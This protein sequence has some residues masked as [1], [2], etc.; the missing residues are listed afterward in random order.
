MAR[1]QNGINQELL[2]FFQQAVGLSFDL[3]VFGAFEDFLQRV[4]LHVHW[5]VLG[6]GHQQL[7]DRTGKIHSQRSLQSRHTSNMTPL[8]PL[9]IFI[10]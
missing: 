8:K 6:V 1:I 10:L 7:M 3:F 4:A 2:Q 5:N 9:S